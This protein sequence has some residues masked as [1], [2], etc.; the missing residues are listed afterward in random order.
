MM[1]ILVRNGCTGGVA[2][3]REPAAFGVWRVGRH[4]GADGHP[5]R[6]REHDMHGLDALLLIGALF[7]VREHDLA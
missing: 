5:L 2:S 1:M 7:F 3:K 6:V 4:A